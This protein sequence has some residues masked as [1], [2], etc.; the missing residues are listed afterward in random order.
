MGGASCGPSHRYGVDNVAA[1]RQIIL[2]IVG[3]IA[4]STSSSPVGPTSITRR[5]NPSS[6][7]RSFDAIVTDRWAGYFAFRPSVTSVSG[8]W[9]VPR[10]S[11]SSVDTRSST[12]IGAGG[13]SGGTLLQVGMYDNCLGGVAVQGAFAEEYPGST[14]SFQ[15]D[16]RSGDV[17]TATVAKSSSSWYARITDL[18]TR[19]S[20]IAR[21]SNYQGGTSAEW[22]VE[23]YGLPEGNPLTS[24]GSERL[25]TFLIDGTLASISSTDVYEMPHVTATDPATGTYRLIYRGTKARSPRDAN[26]A[27]PNLETTPETAA[28]RS[29]PMR[30]TSHTKSL[31]A[32]DVLAAAHR[33]REAS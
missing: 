3:L 32:D 1:V 13:I 25:R 7:G 16:I 14:V 29:N 17:V 24:F 12:W 31:F 26:R 21:A 20:A 19:Q 4:I 8:T 18:T 23:A 28:L 22:M 9:S 5:P 33:P 30:I 2:A 6:G 15:L 27:S 11:C 10:L